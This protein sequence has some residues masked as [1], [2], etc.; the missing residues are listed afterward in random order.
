MDGLQL[1]YFA[2]PMCSWCYGFSPVVQAMRR[3]YAGVLPIRLVLGG[4]RPGT[5]TPMPDDARRGLVHHWDEIGAMA[6]V[7]FS[8]ALA[9]RE[10]FIYDTDPAAR[11]V[12]LARRLSDDDGLDMLE[13]THKAFYAEGR[14]VTDNAVL[15]DIAASLD[16]D[17]DS[18]LAGLGQESLKDETWGDYA[19]ARNAGVTGFPTLIVGPNADGTY[20]PVTRGYNDADVVLAGVEMWLKGVRPAAE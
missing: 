19:I 18:F 16:F 5:T 2:D 1:I 10:G 13:E 20:A 15:A 3:R 11:A 4:L 14:D 9:D 12:V 7:P 8:P 6:G 17:R